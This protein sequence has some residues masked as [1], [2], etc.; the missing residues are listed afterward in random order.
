MNSISLIL[1]AVAVASSVAC[2]VPDRTPDVGPAL[3]TSDW[4]EVTPQNGVW[5]EDYRRTDDPDDCSF[6]FRTLR[7]ARA[8]GVEVFVRDDV[9]IVDNCPSNSLSCTTWRDDCLEVF[10]DGDDD[11]NPNTRGADNSRNPQPCNAGG[12]YA[13]AANGAS[14][15]DLASAKKCFGT[16]WGG[17][18]RPWEEN[19]RRVGTHYQV[20]FDYACL[21]RAVPRLDEPFAC[22]FTLCVH[23]DDD[24]GSND[25]ALYWKGNPKRPY[26]DESAF[27]RLE[28]PAVHQK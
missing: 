28:L 13:L 22:G 7:Y 16:L 17:T 8:I 12:E 6:R 21:N 19:G 5:D 25:H 11:R 4:T 27:G 15:S 9:T 3:W 1:S 2:A 24:G 10:F 14:Q 18:I 26:A 23:D 20:W